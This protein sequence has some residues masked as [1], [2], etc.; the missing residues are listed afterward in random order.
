MLGQ[1]LA[2]SQVYS[3]TGLSIGSRQGAQPDPTLKKPVE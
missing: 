3:N 2:M 1:F